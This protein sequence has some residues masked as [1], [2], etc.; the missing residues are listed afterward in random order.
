M[1]TNIY[2]SL[3]QLYLEYNR[4]YNTMPGFFEFCY[5]FFEIWNLYL[6]KYSEEDRQKKFLLDVFRYISRD[7]FSNKEE[8]MEKNKKITLQKNIIKYKIVLINIIDVILKYNNEKINE[9]SNVEAYKSSNTTL[10]IIKL[11][12]ENDRPIKE[13]EI[14]KFGFFQNNIPTKEIFEVIRFN[15]KR[16][17]TNNKF[18]DVMIKKLSKM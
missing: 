8:K 13:E 3:T 12:L 9:G 10:S 18:L 6:D 14:K 2:E 15:L 1:K 16:L 5:K 4:P 7:P 17:P 11:H